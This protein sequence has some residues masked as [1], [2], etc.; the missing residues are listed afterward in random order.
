MEWFKSG[1]ILPPSNQGGFI[2]L[3]PY[4]GSLSK[5]LV[6]IM[7]SLQ[8]LLHFRSDS[9]QYFS[10]EI[11]NSRLTVLP[12]VADEWVLGR[13]EVLDDVLVE[14]VHVLHQPLGGAVVDLA[15]VVQDG[16]VGVTFEIALDKFG[17]GGVGVVEL[18]HEGCV[19]GLG[20]PALLVTEGHDTHGLQVM[21]ISKRQRA[22]CLI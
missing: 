22:K 18:L 17:M 15:G 13:L 6:L 5:T 4:G 1:C 21:D 12:D 11:R 20:E 16:E 8:E 2:R 19:C 10:S 3:P 9:L 7:I 14:R